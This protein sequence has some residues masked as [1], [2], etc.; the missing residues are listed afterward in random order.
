MRRQ[1]EHDQREKEPGEHERVPVWDSFFHFIF[2]QANVSLE[3]M[4]KPR[5]ARVPKSPPR[6]GWALS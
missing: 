5:S 3:A 2:P 4:R 6:L 1:N